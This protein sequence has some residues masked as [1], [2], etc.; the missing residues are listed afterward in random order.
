MVGTPEDNRKRLKR[1]SVLFFSLCICVFIVL[2]LLGAKTYTEGLGSLAQS[3]ESAFSE[4]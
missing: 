3:I 2:S 4:C 1:N